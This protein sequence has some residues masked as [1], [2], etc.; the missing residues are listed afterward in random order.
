MPVGV[1]LEQEMAVDGCFL[2]SN[3][4][5]RVLQC[6]EDLCNTSVIKVLHFL[7]FFLKTLFLYLT[8]REREIT[9]RQRG[10]QRERGKQAP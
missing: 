6:L 9:S 2:C 1:G 8:E 10:R 7:F 3:R 4:S 5:S